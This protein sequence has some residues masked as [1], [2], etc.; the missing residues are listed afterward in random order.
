[1]AVLLCIFAFGQYTGIANYNYVTPY[2]H[3][4]THALLLSIAMLVLL[5]RA[6]RGGTPLLWAA[7]GLCLGGVLLTKL[8]L[9]LPALLAGLVG[10][11]V[12]EAGQRSASRRMAFAGAAL[13][14]AL[15][16]WIL[17]ARELPAAEALRG[18]LGNLAHLEPGLLADGFYA[19]VAGLDDPERSAARVFRASVWLGGFAA[20]ALLLDRWLAARLSAWAAALVGVAVFAGLA[21]AVP[22]SFWLG[23]AA[24]LPVACL[25]AV[26][27]IGVAWR[28]AEAA[29]RR[30]LTPLLLWGVWSLAL[31][32]K[33]GLRARFGHYGFALAMPATLLLVGLLAGELP[34]RLRAR[35]RGGR[36][37]TAFVTAGVAACALG[38]LQ[39]SAR[40]YA[41]KGLPVGPAGDVIL[42]ERPHVSPRPVR[43]SAA[44]ERIAALEPAPTS[45]VVLPEGSGLNYW[46]RIRNP[47]P[48]TLFLPTEIRAFGEGA[49]LAALRAASP[50]VVVLVHRGHR[51]F[52]VGR[53]GVDPRYGRGLMRWVTEEYEPIEAIGPEPFGADGFGVALLRRRM[54]PPGDERR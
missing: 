53:F 2:H 24:A 29:E 25:A 17:L 13:L 21:F 35:Y 54:P 18:V 34:R 11:R 4:Q 14:P 28:R 9:A 52:G 47:V 15:G 16:F 12:A 40:V 7:A 41:H 33:L 26:L 20:L 5:V 49:M 27:A 36:L 10:L 48:Y 23:L 19:R 50:D 6:G 38:C 30:R 46:L 42:A 1:M 45:L 39:I 8:E 22:A 3:T 31:L 51:E 44:L 32:A 37:A 43:V